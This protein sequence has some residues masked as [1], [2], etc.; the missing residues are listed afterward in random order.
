MLVIKCAVIGVV[1]SVF[2]LL[3]KKKNGEFSFLLI[4]SAGAVMILLVSSDIIF[5]FDEIKGIFNTIGIN[6]T[7]F[8]ILLKTLGICIIAQFA[9]DTC[10]DFGNKT[11]AGII[12]L[13]GKISILVISLPL[14]KSILDIVTGLIN[15]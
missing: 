12:M 14:M 11:I 15:Q 13:V 2:A 9:A 1:A 8:K 6:D 7:Y 4:L 5:A 3:L 10:C